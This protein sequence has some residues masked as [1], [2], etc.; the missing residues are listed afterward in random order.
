M[1]VFRYSE[2]PPQRSAVRPRPGGSSLYLF[3]FSTLTFP[4]S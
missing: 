2:V 1:P 4:S 3:L